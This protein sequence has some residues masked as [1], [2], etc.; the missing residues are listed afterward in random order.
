[1]RCGRAQY[2]IGGIQSEP[3][4]VSSH[5]RGRALL[6]RPGVPPLERSPLR[7]PRRDADAVRQG[8]QVRG[9]GSSGT[10]CEGLSIVKIFPSVRSGATYRRRSEGVEPAGSPL[11]R[12][13][14]LLLKISFDEQYLF[15]LGCVARKGPKGK[16]MRASAGPPRPEQ[17]PRAH[18]ATSGSEC[19]GESSRARRA[20]CRLRL[21]SSVRARSEEIGVRGA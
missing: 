6:G 18:E 10:V 7:R 15:S 11:A 4:G 3:K 20:R 2:V 13:D 14:W 1:M 19:T 8:P 21:G 9:V 5:G 12:A 16:G 17:P